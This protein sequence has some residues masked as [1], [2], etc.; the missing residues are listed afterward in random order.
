[1]E[2]SGKLQEKWKKVGR[3]G[4]GS[5]IVIPDILYNS[6][7]TVYEFEFHIINVVRNRL[8][9]LVVNC[10]LI[11]SRNAEESEESDTSKYA[12]CIRDYNLVI[13]HRQ[14]FVLIID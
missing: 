11:S 5:I 9:L 7:L 14:N 6:I 8:N 1:M 4:R 13:L 12:C 10:I 2:K 3:R